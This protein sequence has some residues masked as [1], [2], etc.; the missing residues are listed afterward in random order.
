MGMRDE[1]EA[2]MAVETGL[3]VE[4]F[5]RDRLGDT[6][7]AIGPKYA[8]WSWQ[9]SRKALA[10][11]MPDSGD[12]KYWV[13]YAEVDGQCFEWPLYNADVRT[14]IKATGAKVIE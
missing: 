12:A 3:P 7:Q 6:Y 9:E 2:A 8:W 10:V 11:N 1:F 13:E 5:E 4:V 14:A